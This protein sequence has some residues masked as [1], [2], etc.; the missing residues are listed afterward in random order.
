MT[1]QQ[2]DLDAF[3]GRFAGDLASA[4]HAATVVVGDKL[5]L[6][7]VLAERGPSTP[8]ELAEATG[9]DERYLREW[10][11]AQAASEYACYDPATERFHLDPAQRTVTLGA[12]TAS[13]R[14]TII[15]PK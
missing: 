3:V 12:T 5:G 15:A 11:S 10:L 1:I 8:A 7:Q 2:A 4:L 6:F 14:C 13:P 9:C